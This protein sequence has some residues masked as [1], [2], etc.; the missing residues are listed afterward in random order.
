MNKYI[1]TRKGYEALVNLIRKT[2]EMLKKVTKAKTEAGSGQDSWHE[3]V[4]KW[5]LWKK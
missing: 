2:E 1:F 4:L 3:K 5:A